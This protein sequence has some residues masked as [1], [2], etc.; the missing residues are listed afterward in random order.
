[1]R[2]FSKDILRARVK[3]DGEIALVMLYTKGN[4]L[5]TATNRWRN[6]TSFL[7]H[8]ILTVTKSQTEI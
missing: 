1:M 4:G 5:W 7:S 8:T 3:E 2:Q 6:D